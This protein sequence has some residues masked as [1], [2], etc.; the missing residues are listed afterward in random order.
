VPAGMLFVPSDGGVSHS[1]DEHTSPEHCDL[2]VRVLVRTL[3][4][5][6]G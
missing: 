4:E 1:P 6:A 2:G 5:L 3:R